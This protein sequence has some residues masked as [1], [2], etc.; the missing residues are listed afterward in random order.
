[1]EKICP[2]CNKLTIPE[3]KCSRCKG[4]MDDLGRAQE[5]LSDD[6]TSN[7]PINDAFNYCIHVAKCERC[8]ETQN[9]QINKI[10]V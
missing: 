9:I 8:N 4:T 7:M 5:V 3:I 6:Y 10:T 2:A 1:M